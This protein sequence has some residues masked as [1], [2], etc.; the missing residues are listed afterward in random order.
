M[1][2]EV[3]PQPVAPTTADDDLDH[4]YCECTPDIAFCG[5][6][7]STSPIVDESSLNEVCALCDVLHE[8]ND[9]V[10]ARCGQ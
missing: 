5:E 10:C 6:D 3:L 8:A 4:I 9:G 7:V 1:S 2:V